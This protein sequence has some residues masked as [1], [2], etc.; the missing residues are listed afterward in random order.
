MAQAPGAPAPS[1]LRR[2]LPYAG[3]LIGFWALLPP[4]T[5]PELNT[6][7]RVEVADH[8]VP[9]VLMLGLSVATLVRARR[10]PDQGAFGLAAGL[11]IALAGLWMTATHV[12]LVNQ[13]RD[14]LVSAGGAAW[15]TV[16]GLVV[17]ALGVVWSSAYWSEDAEEEQ[18][19][20][21]EPVASEPVEEQR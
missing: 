10:N 8:V 13:A 11:G 9:S 6:E 14:D 15:H 21:S 4:Y 2:I 7:T 17:M 12:P 19:T 5:G 3:L 18:A 16:P 1:R 20:A